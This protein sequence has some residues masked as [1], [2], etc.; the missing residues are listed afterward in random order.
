[1]ADL[2]H[3]WNHVDS[4]RKA[5][6]NTRDKVIHPVFEAHSGS[7]K[8]NNPA[9]LFYY[10]LKPPSSIFHNSQRAPSDC[11]SNALQRSGGVYTKIKASQL[12]K[13]SSCLHCI[14]IPLAK[15][16]STIT[17][18]A[19]ISNMDFFNFPPEIRN[20]IYAI[21]LEDIVTP[22]DHVG[23]DLFPSA[24]RFKPY[25]SLVLVNRLLK[26]EA[27]SFLGFKSARQAVFYFED[28]SILYSMQ[29]KIL[30]CSAFADARVCLRVPKSELRWQREQCVRNDL[31][32]LMI[33]QCW[34]RKWGDTPEL[35]CYEL[36]TGIDGD[37]DCKRTNGDHTHCDPE[38]GY[39]APYTTRKWPFT[40]DAICLQS[41]HWPPETC[42]SAARHGIMVQA[43]GSVTLECKLRDIDWRQFDMHRARMHS[44]RL[45]WKKHEIRFG[46]EP[47]FDATYLRNIGCGGQGGNNSQIL[48]SDRAESE[49]TSLGTTSEDD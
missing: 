22:L 26:D 39:C 20:M 47:D 45:H 4:W 3:C 13:A 1:M 28:A 21:V 15:I 46:L 30:R 33:Q 34:D 9:A 11:H 36:F 37:D 17:L 31:G 48:I 38:Q 12:L 5:F 16:N 32:S 23:Y 10:S 41:F 2:I 27:T 24:A 18:R 35:S 29:Q 6:L 49:P 43:S 7:T 8:V 19:T 42:C 14:S 40:T 44:A 25:H